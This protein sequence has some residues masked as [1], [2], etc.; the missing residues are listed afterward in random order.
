M[1][2]FSTNAAGVLVLSTSG[3]GQYIKQ[4]YSQT[5]Q[6]LTQQKWLIQKLI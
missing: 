4:T 6:F 1:N 2:K 3:G 5:L